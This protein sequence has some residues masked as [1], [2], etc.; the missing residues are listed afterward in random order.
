[1]D[2]IRL[3]SACYAVCLSIYNELII[4]QLSRFCHKIYAKHTYAV[5]D[6]ELYKKVVKNRMI[7]AVP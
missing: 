3:F 2:E 1:M 6:F 5:L 7:R 4:H